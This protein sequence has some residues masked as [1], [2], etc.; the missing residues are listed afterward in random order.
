MVSASGI[1]EVAFWF[2]RLPTT[3]EEGLNA[4]VGFAVGPREQL[5]SAVGRPF[6]V[7]VGL[8]ACSL[9]FCRSC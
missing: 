1:L 6:G 9:W 8:M 7:V 3:E 2:E 5:K 4:C